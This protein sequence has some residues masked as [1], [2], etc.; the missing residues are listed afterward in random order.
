MTTSSGKTGN[1]RMIH[2][3]LEYLH[4]AHR[5]SKQTIALIAASIDDFESVAGKQDFKRF[6]PAWAIKYK[7]CLENLEFRRT[8]SGKYSRRCYAITD[9]RASSVPLAGST[10]SVRK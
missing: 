10:M 2:H 9:Q 6:K 3:Y 1:A 4:E 5:R 7:D 8:R